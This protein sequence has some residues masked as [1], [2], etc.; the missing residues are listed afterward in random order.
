MHDVVTRLVD[1]PL[2]RM[3]VLAG[4]IFL[5]VAVLGR[6]EGKIEPGKLGR[7]GASVVG[8][9]L[10]LVGLA[11]HALE[12]EQL[13]EWL[14]ESAAQQ[15]AAERARDAGA[16]GARGHV[17][18]QAAAAE[19]GPAKN[20]G[21][22]KYAIKVLAGTYGRNCGAKP[23]NA[24][25]HLARACDGRASCDYRIDASTLEDP[26]PSCDKD[27][28]AEWRCGAGPAVYAAS[29]SGEAGRGG[30]LSLVCSSR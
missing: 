6:I 7:I 13:R 5:L 23:G 4:V 21:E 22:E 30:S 20:A 12:G 16:A 8:S 28:A 11:M 26:A 15:P 1:V 24:T 14:R 18:R 19:K 10:L 3:F 25:A 29:V 9:I 2:T 27:Y 17:V